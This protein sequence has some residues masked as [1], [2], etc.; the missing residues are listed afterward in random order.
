MPYRRVA[1]EEQKPYVIVERTA[2]GGFHL[3]SNVAARAESFR[4]AS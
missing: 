4:P 1:I 3:Q 2:D